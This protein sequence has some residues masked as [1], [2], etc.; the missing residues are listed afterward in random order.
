M[1]LCGDHYHWRWCAVRG[2]V[3]LGLNIM[4]LNRDMGLGGG[5]TFLRNLA[6]PLQRRGHRCILV[7]GPGREFESSLGEST[8]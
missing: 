8:R 2:E 1:P 6:P 5:N 3:T 7:C 4:M